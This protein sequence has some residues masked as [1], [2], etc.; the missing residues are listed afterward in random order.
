MQLTGGTN[1][2]KMSSS[3][4]NLGSSSLSSL[5]SSAT[6]RCVLPLSIAY[7]ADRTA[8]RP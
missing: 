5:G 4:S 6:P 8:A 7:K 2:M 3:T 1:Q